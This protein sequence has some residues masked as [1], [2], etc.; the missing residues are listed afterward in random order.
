MVLPKWH[1]GKAECWGRRSVGVYIK[2]AWGTIFYGSVDKYAFPSG[3][4]TSAPMCQVS[5]E[6][7]TTLQAAWTAISGKTTKDYAPPL[8]FCRP[9]VEEAG[10]DI[11]YYAIGNWK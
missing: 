11:L 1:S 7:G 4:F 6:F 10:F 2:E 3:L 9:M 5:A 8:F